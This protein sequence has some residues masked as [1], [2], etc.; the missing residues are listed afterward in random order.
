MD[1]TLIIRF[2]ARTLVLAGAIVVM[3]AAFLPWVRLPPFLVGDLALRGLSAGG[4]ATLALAFIAALSLLLPW[5]PLSRVS[6]PAAFLSV[7][8]H[9]I[10][11][12]AFVRTVHW[13][14]MLEMDPLSH[15]RL[16]PTG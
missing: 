3:V 5:Q 1:R 2:D 10:A 8:I 12:A 7:W 6:L 15:C 16:R 9:L 14:T 4:W 13:A 11:L